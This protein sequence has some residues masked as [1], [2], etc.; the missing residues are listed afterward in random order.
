M[1]PRSGGEYVT[2]LAVLVV[3][4]VVVSGAAEHQRPLEPRELAA[5][6]LTPAAF[7]QFREA[8]D[9][10]ARVI[11]DDPAFVAEPLFSQEVVQGGEVAEV[12]ARLEARLRDHRGLHAALRTA[13]MTPR[14]YTTFALTLVA[15][16]L[17]LGFLDAG[18]LKSVPAGAAT[19]NVAFVRAHRAEVDRV[20]QRLAIEVK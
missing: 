7:A 17:S 20:L 11:A 10:V 18:V 14:A 4:V 8:S 9:S 6:R 15:A 16:R 12:S 1:V 13:G 5:Y 3:C 2:V 19:E